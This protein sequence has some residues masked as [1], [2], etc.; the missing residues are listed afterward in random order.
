[1]SLSQ[2]RSLSLV[3][4][5]LTLATVG[6]ATM[7]AIQLYR[8]PQETTNRLQRLGLLLTGAHEETCNVHG[9]PMRYY[10]A[11]HR[12]SPIVLIHGLG[13]NAE[14]WTNLIPLL[15]RDHIV[16]VPDMPGFGKT[17]LAPEGI[18]IRTHALYVGRFL[19]A[20]GLSTATLIG[21]SLG[22]WIAIIFALAHP[23]RVTHLFLLNSAGLRRENMLSP[24]AV[25]RV[26]AQH[27]VNAMLGYR[28]PLPGFALDA[29]VR[30]SAAPA[31]KNF[32]EG[33]DVQEELDSV[34]S[35][36]HVPTTIIWG[37]RDGIFP[38]TCATDFHAGIAHS[39]L[40]LLPGV[41]HMPQSQ[42]PLKVAHIVRE[43]LR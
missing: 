38:L 41:G 18:N 43:K 40:I 42:A 25:D 11:G 17:P 14:S 12:G 10:R 16:Y 32:I 13:S 30:G 2:K 36:V 26:A 7:L 35:D 23:H 9:L 31:Y 4:T 8:H 20:L 6:G 1:M 19:D 28:M 21:N 22:G 3:P 29:F 33:Y 39:D 24:Y 27:A 34:L 37:E 5:L 15:S